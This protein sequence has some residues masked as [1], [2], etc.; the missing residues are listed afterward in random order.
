M[1]P[2]IVWQSY[3]IFGDF[4]ATQCCHDAVNESFDHQY[5]MRDSDSMKICMVKTNTLAPMDIRHP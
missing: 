2:R 1:A 3:C 5:A 4:P